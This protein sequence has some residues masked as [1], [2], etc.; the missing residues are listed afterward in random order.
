MSVS[1]LRNCSNFFDA[2]RVEFAPG[3]A[4]RGPA[5]GLGIELHVGRFERAG[6]R[7]AVVVFQREERRLL[8]SVA[9]AA[10]VGERARFDLPV[11]MAVELAVLLAFDV[12]R[13][14]I[15]D[16]ALRNGDQPEVER[17]RKAADDQR[18]EEVGPH[19]AAERHA[20]REHRHDLGLV[21]H[22]RGEEDAGDEGEQTAELVD[23]EGNEVQVIVEDDVPERGVQLRE[24]VDLLYIVE[25]HHDDDD[26]RDGEEVGRKE[27]AEYVAV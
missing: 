10:D 17:Q 19:Q 3:V 21:G 16:M 5:F 20:A 2:Q 9:V 7:A 8:R 12:L 18:A 14:E 4:G 1:R 11:D 22:L 15:D 26:H 6:H 25:Q 24:V 27:L 23:E 13:F